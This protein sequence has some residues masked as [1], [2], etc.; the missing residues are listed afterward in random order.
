MPSYDVVDAIVA[1][2]AFPGATAF[3]GSSVRQGL[4]HLSRWKNGPVFEKGS[5]LNVQRIMR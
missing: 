4:K 3:V 1:E 2:T 5:R